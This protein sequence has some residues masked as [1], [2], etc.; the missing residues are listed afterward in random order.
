LRFF[1]PRTRGEELFVGFKYLRENFSRQGAK[2]EDGENERECFFIPH[3]MSF[4]GFRFILNVA[5]ST[6]IGRAKVK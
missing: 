4:D 6:P 1:A 2:E 3:L 5:M